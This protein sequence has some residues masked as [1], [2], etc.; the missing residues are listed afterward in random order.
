M[1]R[2]CKY[3]YSKIYKIIVVGHPEVPPFIGSTTEHYLAHRY[4]GHVNL[5]QKWQNGMGR[6][7][8]LYD[9]FDKYGFDNCQ[10]VLIKSLSCDTSDQL[11]AKEDEVRLQYQRTKLPMPKLTVKGLRL[12]SAIKSF[13]LDTNQIKFMRQL[14][15]DEEFPS[16]FFIQ[17]DSEEVLTGSGSV[18]A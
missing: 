18:D 16:G 14:I 15:I 2:S 11:R 9:L 3:H 5:Y 4:A 8:T 10:I 1:G 12:V 7:R 17:D 6:Y 13:N